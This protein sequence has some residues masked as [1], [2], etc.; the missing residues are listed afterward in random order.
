MSIPS[1]GFVLPFHAMISDDD[2]QTSRSESHTSGR[3]TT[4]LNISGPRWVMCLSPSPY[5]SGKKTV[6]P[7]K[8]L[9]Q[10]RMKP[11]R[12]EKSVKNVSYGYDSYTYMFVQHIF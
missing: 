1:I 10:I 2:F 6:W 4:L 5:F 9:L 7:S 3:R 8:S 12:G 11:W